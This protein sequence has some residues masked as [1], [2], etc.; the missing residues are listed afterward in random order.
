MYIL[1]TVL[2]YVNGFVKVKCFFSCILLFIEFADRCTVRKSVLKRGV[3]FSGNGG[4]MELNRK[5]SNA[6]AFSV[7]PERMSKKHIRELAKE[8]DIDLKGI[9]L[10]IDF[11]EEK[12]RLQYTGRA[13]YEK[14]GQITFF[15]N[16]FQSKEELVRTLYH[17][18]QHVKQYKKYGTQHVVNNRLHFEN[19]AYSLEEEFIAKIKERG[20]I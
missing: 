3:D 20:I 5:T 17:E 6:G 8:C 19:E 11:D 10:D 18:I 12:L 7:L 9:T 1:T 15:H 4:I 2:L 13:D 14:I 16:A